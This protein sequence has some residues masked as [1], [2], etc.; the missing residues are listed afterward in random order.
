M[1]AGPGS[2]RAWTRNPSPAADTSRRPIEGSSRVG[3]A[4][5]VS[6]SGTCLSGRFLL[7]LPPVA[8]ILKSAAR[9]APPDSNRMQG[10]RALCRAGLSAAAFGAPRGPIPSFETVNHAHAALVIEIARKAF[11]ADIRPENHVDK[12]AVISYGD[13]FARE[14]ACQRMLRNAQEIAR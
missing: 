3:Q 6:L 1:T 8:G 2:G 4:S 5:P 13:A 11:N 9:P 14:I 12:H 10:H 7:G